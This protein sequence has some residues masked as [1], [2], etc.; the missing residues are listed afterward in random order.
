MEHVSRAVFDQESFYPFRRLVEGPL[1]ELR[2]LP[3]LERFLRVA[4]LHDD[5][6]MCLQPGPGPDEESE[7][8]D[9]DRRRGVRAVIVSFGPTL[10][11]YE[12]LLSRAPAPKPH[13]VESELSP[14]LAELAVEYANAGTGDPYFEAHVEYLGHLAYVLKSGGSVVCDGDLGRDAFEHHTEFPHHLFR[15]LNEDWESYAKDAYKGFEL[16]LP[17]VLSI[18]LN[19]A[20][21]R[22]AIPTIVNDLRAE[23]S[24]A[25]KK[26]WNLVSA[27]KTVR[28]LHERHEIR[29]EFKEAA[30]WFSPAREHELFTHSPLRMVLDV[31]VASALGKSVA[32]AV[33]KLVS[34]GVENLATGRKLLGAGAFDLARRVRMNLKE[35]ERTADLLPRVLSPGEIEHL[36]RATPHESARPAMSISDIES[37]ARELV[38]KRFWGEIKHSRLENLR[39]QPLTRMQRKKH[40]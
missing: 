15:D 23:W 14:R 4:V 21:R 36:S 33:G 39:P 10:D 26:L 5:M 17:P 12:P 32:G 3:Q 6:A 25:R 38:G 18:V 28:T 40:K 30:R 7:W 27:E 1:T 19:R 22:D 11:K 29:R 2:D 9:E 20:A 16:T 34:L 8:S 31:F 24:D 13:L 37:I 35:V